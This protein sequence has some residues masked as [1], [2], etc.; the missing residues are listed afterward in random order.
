MLPFRP[1]PATPMQSAVHSPRR[2]VGRRISV[3]TTPTTNWR[4]SGSPV[5]PDSPS[6]PLHSPLS[7]RPTTP[8]DVHSAVSRLLGLM[9]QLQEVLHLWGMRQA[10][11]AQVSDAFVLVAAQFNTTVN[12]FY[13]HSIDMS[14]LYDIIPDLREVL[15]SCLGEDP[16]PQALE[17]YMPDVRLVIYRLLTGLR[18]KQGPYWQVVASS[19]RASPLEPNRKT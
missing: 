7:S 8:T 6:S 15:E 3:R 2:Q 16:S 17:A 11:Q 14:D 18:S 4:R 10:T 9:K 13:R 12:A 1:L 5:T 19:R